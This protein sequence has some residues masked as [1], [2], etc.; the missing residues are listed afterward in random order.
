MH[1]LKSVI[2]ITAK[3]LGIYEDKSLRKAWLND[4]SQFGGAVP[5]EWRSV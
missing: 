2:E 5:G 4:L 3:P 1:S